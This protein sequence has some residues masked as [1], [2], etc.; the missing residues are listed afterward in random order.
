M[1][2]TAM[3]VQN[4]EQIARFAIYMTDRTDILRIVYDR[5]KGSILPVSKKFRFAQIKKSTMVDSGTR[6]TEVLYE[7]APEFRNAVAELEQLMDAREDSHH[8]SQL[9][10]EEVHA[11]EEDVASRIDYIKSLVEKL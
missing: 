6:R 1:A 10:A 11:L 2:L 5:K 9:I 3:G 7:S 8:V 4:P